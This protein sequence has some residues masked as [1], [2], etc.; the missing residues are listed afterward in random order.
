MVG[1]FLPT[2]ERELLKK[3][4]DALDEE[5]DGEL[6]PDE[7]IGMFHQ[8]FNLQLG[9]KDMQRMLKFMDFGGGDGLIQFTEFLIAGSNKAVLLSDGNLQKEFKFLDLDQ[10]GFIGPEDIE[11]FMTGMCS[12][13]II[14][15]D[16]DM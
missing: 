5:R 8:K 12:E 7:F 15:K 2:K 11:T 1:R 13:E 16:N 4:F 3:I 10:D 9:I 14:K 6:E